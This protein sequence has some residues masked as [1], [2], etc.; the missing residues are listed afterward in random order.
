MALLHLLT[1]ESPSPENA[2]RLLRDQIRTCELLPGQVL[3]E[4][5][6]AAGLGIDVAPA[7]SA[8]ARL[9]AHGVV[10]RLPEAGYQVPPL[11]RKEVDDLFLAWRLIGPEIARLGIASASGPQLDAMRRLVDH[12]EVAEEKRSSRTARLVG[13]ADAAFTLLAVATTNDRL[14]ETY[15]SFRLEMARV[16]SPLLADPA[17]P[18]LLRATHTDWR[19]ALDQR[20]GERAA[21]ISRDF[22]EASYRLVRQ[23]T[24]GAPAS[25]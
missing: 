25:V 16:W 4:R 18:S 17:G 12:E 14:V 20:N 19:S 10:R 6:V 11:T 7:A 24:C 5:R 2:Y 13:V 8:L 1:P 9:A 3:T 22:I 15:R 23:L 21:E